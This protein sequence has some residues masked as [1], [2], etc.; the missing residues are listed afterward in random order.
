MAET[1]AEMTTQ[2]A[3]AGVSPVQLMQAISRISPT[4]TNTVERRPEPRALVLTPTGGSRARSPSSAVLRWGK[5][6]RY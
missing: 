3:E 6:T 4:K 2:L 5:K 1:Q